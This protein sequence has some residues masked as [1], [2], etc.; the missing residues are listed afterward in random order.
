MQT[1]Y[2]DEGIE[3]GIWPSPVHLA[4][5]IYAFHRNISM[6]INI[7]LRYKK[8]VELTNVFGIAQL[9]YSIKNFENDYQLF[10]QKATH[11]SNG[12]E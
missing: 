7:P 1:W 9:D 4:I 11:M 8:I 2:V 12:G 3:D 10:H 6:V 5:K